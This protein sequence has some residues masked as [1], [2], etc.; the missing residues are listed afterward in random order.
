MSTRTLPFSPAAAVA[1]ATVVLAIPEVVAG[2]LSTSK[3]RMR[4][5]AVW[6]H[7]LPEVL[8]R[9]SSVLYIR[10]SCCLSLE[11]CINMI[12]KAC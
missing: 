1:A 8:N 5:F 3:Y 6:Q 9:R 10:F 2:V 7:N 12:I 11:K 4:F